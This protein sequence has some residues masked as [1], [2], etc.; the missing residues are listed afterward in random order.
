MITTIEPTTTCMIGFIFFK[1]EI[2]LLKIIGVVLIVTAVIR[3]NY[4]KAPEEEA[5]LEGE[6][7][8]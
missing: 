5:V 3:L 1:E 6:S 4:N 7:L 8:L 2:N